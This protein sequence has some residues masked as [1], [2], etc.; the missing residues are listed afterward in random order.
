MAAPAR[1]ARRD[2]QRDGWAARTSR[3]QDLRAEDGLRANQQRGRPAREPA[4]RRRRRP[5]RGRKTACARQQEDDLRA[6]AGRP[7]RG[8][9]KTAGRARQQ[10]EVAAAAIR[11]RERCTCAVRRAVRRAGWERSRSVPSIFWSGMVPDLE[12][13]FFFWS[14]SVLV[15]F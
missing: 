13:I 11:E 1:S 15:S 9:R 12:G 5:A 14:H 2:Q 6:A 3:E 8:S 10:R 7:T 4:G